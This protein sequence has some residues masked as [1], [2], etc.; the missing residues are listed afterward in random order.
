[1][2]VGV[3][4]ASP[5]EMKVPEACDRLAPP[6]LTSPHP[7]PQFRT[8]SGRICAHI[9]KFAGH[10]RRFELRGPLHICSYQGWPS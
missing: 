3:P 6:L 7:S 2:R 10:V 4:S 9:P 1:M 8:S 5:V